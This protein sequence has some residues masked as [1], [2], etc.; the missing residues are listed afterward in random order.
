[1]GKAGGPEGGGRSRCRAPEVEGLEAC[2]GRHHQRQLPR[3]VILHPGAAA[4]AQ[5]CVASVCEEMAAPFMTFPWQ[6]MDSCRPV[7]SDMN[8]GVLPAGDRAHAV[9]HQQGEDW[10]LRKVKKQER[11]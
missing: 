6:E 10:D 9:L 11:L 7:A 1:M 4:V 5:W 3:A 2:Q 8:R